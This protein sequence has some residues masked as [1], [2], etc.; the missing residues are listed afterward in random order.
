MGEHSDGD[1]FK[2]RFAQKRKRNTMQ[3]NANN[4]TKLY[5]LSNQNN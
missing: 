1:N 3:M 5:R 4:K 2:K